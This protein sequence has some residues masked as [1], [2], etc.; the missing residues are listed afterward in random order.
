M[1]N[2][3]ALFMTIGHFLQ[4]LSG[5]MSVAVVM[6]I[7][8]C[9]DLKGWGQNQSSNQAW[10]YQLLHDSY[11]IDDCLICGRPTVQVPMHGSFGLR[12]IEENVLSA[13]YAVEDIQFHT[14]DQRYQVKGSGTF[15]I[16]GEVA[17]TFRMTLQV[18]IDD[19]FTNKVCYFTNSLSTMAR[20]WPMMDITL[21]QTNGTFSQ[22]FTL[23]I[24]AAPLREIWFS[25]LSGFT[26]TNSQASLSYVEGGDLISTTG[27]V[28]KRNADLF[29]SVGAFPPVP[30]LG[31]DALDV[32]PGG[33]IAFSLGSGIFSSTLGQLQEGDLLSNKGRIIRR[34]QDLLASFMT[35]TATN[36]AGLDTVHV[37]ET[38]E[39]VFSIVTN[40]FA[41]GLNTWLHPGDLLSSTGIVMRTNHQLLTR[42]HPANPANDYGLD[43]LY[44]WPSGEIWFS[45]ESNFEDQMFGQVLSGDLLSDQGYIVLRNLE[46]LEAFRPKEALPDFGLDTLYVVTDATPPEP[47][48]L[49]TIK[50]G[51]SADSATLSW[52]GQARVFQV[53]RADSAAGPFQP[54]SPMLPDLLFEDLGT[55]TNH[56]Q[57]FYRLQQW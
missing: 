35:E 33:E 13:R 5:Q 32:L 41:K 42:F 19:G 46:L 48:A 43:G 8:L 51:G 4:K 29:T 56:A 17:V 24:A 47:G 57:S 31:L 20:T 1:L 30:D 27:G 12:L 10:S 11:L 7:L 37:L 28:V 49:L 9:P 6:L 54:L 14:V 38:G 52:Q 36:D 40:V 55:G 44:V 2:M 21:G 50:T 26:P 22:V 3:A 45:T 25:T 39:I 23:R 16:G 18:T 34:N 15:E 53:Q